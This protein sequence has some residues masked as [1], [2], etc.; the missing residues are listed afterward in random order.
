MK[1][2]ISRFNQILYLPSNP[3]GENLN[4][5]SLVVCRA[6]ESYSRL[7]R[8]KAGDEKEEKKDCK[9]NKKCI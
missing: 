9:W 8:K 1:I 2:L 6:T 7:P 5:F 3:E 4:G